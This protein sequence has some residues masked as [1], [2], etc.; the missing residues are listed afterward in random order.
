MS[1]MP[2]MLIGLVATTASAWLFHGPA[3]YGA[4]LLAG[5]D[6]QVQ[7]LV[8]RQEVPEV[9]AAFT[10]DPMTRR[11]EFTGPANDFQRRRFVELIQEAEILGIKSV[12]WNPRSPAVNTSPTPGARP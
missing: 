10:R 11:L 1:P 12:G 5:L 3:G 2:K 4:R 6:A 7:P 9:R 8:V